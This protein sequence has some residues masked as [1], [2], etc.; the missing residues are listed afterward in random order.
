MRFKTCRV[1]LYLLSLVFSSSVANAAVPSELLSKYITSIRTANDKKL[2]QLKRIDGRCEKLES[3]GPKLDYKARYDQC[4]DAHLKKEKEQSS[5]SDLYKGK[6]AKVV[7]TKQFPSLFGKP[8]N[9]SDGNRLMLGFI[10]ISFDMDNAP[11]IRDSNDLVK[12]GI[13]EVAFERDTG[14]LSD[15]HGMRLYKVIERWTEKEILAAHPLDDLKAFGDFAWTDDREAVTAKLEKIKGIKEVF[16][17]PDNEIQCYESSLPDIDGTRTVYYKENDYELCRPSNSGITGRNINISNAEFNIEFVFSRDCSKMEE[18]IKSGKEEDVDIDGGYVYP[19]YKLLEV[20][21]DAVNI[22][23]EKTQSIK[24]LMRAKYQK[25][26]LKDT[27]DA[28]E[29]AD[30]SGHHIFV[31]NRGEGLAI[32]YANDNSKEVCEK[33]VKRIKDFHNETRVKS[34]KNMED[35]L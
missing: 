23:P 25:Y 14:F 13:Y 29:Y 18:A 19:E 7:E 17:V 6:R 22:S 12:A 27:G 28:E 35:S 10:S 24:N 16:A 33:N 2:I 5:F 34:I 9:L 32:V 15:F 4:V 21:L 26:Y 11:A 20:K 30:R 1:A 8:N 3:L 31:I